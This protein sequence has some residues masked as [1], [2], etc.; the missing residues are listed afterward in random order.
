VCVCVSTIYEDVCVYN[1]IIM[2]GCK[3]DAPMMYGMVG[4]GTGTKESVKK[5]CIERTHSLNCG[6][7]FS[8]L[9]AIKII[10]INMIRVSET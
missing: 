5:Q 9:T 4:T 7:S 8:L 2:R 6:Y 3:P 10:V 1:I